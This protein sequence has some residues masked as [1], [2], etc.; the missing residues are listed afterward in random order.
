M[1]QGVKKWVH[2]CCDFTLQYP[3]VQGR[4]VCFFQGSKVGYKLTQ[5]AFV[6]QY[7]GVYQYAEF[8]FKIYNKI[9]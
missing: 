5:I 1:V 3:F 9:N 4:S 2:R 6:S 7:F 8:V